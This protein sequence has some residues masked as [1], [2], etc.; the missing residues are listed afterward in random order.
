V[1]AGGLKHDGRKSRDSNISGSREM[2]H[3]RGD[4]R[5]AASG[6]D[7]SDTSESGDNE[8]H[9]SGNMEEVGVFVCL[10]AV[11]CPAGGKML[12]A[13]SQL[14]FLREKNWPCVCICV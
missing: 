11:R 10:F 5:M 3:G 13:V 6:T 4:D 1:S 8:D 14:S 2:S 12:A 9:H 7:D